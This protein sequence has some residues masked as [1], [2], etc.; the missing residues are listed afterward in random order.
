MGGK[1]IYSAAAYSNFYGGYKMFGAGSDGSDIGK[2]G[3]E[4]IVKRDIENFKEW[5]WSEVSGAMER[6]FERNNGYAIPSFYASEI[7]HNKKTQIVDETHYSREIG[8]E[9]HIKVIYGF[10]DEA[11]YNKVM[12]IINEWDEST[13]GRVQDINEEINIRESSETP[14]E[15]RE[16][17]ISAAYRIIGTISDN[18]DEREMS[19]LTPY[20]V[21]MIKKCLDVLYNFTD[22][23]RSVRGI[24]LGEYMLDTYPVITCNSFDV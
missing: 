18:M 22:D 23:N 20:Q 21:E 15:S 5:H 19:E 17:R 13:I 2:R 8:G 10:R 4:E 3:V 14:E 16:R 24:D 7:L 11:L 12:G 6:I 9:T 1:H